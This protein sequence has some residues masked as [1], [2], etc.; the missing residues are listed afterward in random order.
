MFTIENNQLKVII[1]TKGAELQSIFHKS[2]QLEYM[3]NA[4]PA[5]WSKRSPVLF[6]IVGTVKDNKYLY[7]NKSYHL[8]RHG[9]ARE[10]EFAAYNQQVDFISFLLKSNETTLKNFP[11][12]FEFRVSYQLHENSLKTTYHILNTSDHD[13]YFS[14]GGHP[15][16]KLPLAEG[17]A[18]SDYYLEFDKNENLLRWPISAGGLIEKNPIPFLE[19]TK[20]LPLNKELFLQDALVFKHPASSS[21]SL[22]SKKTTHGLNFDFPG[23]PY[24][25]IWAA[26][27]ADFV[28]IEPWCGIADSVDADQQLIHKEGIIQLETGKEFERSWEVR[29]F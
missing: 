4:D 19:N 7:D 10:M 22:R 13:I 9:F 24:L 21:V 6:P 16:F 27:N 1:D 29:L 3:W 14:V 25:G 23:F 15:A 26:K 2:F 11:F 12:A 8:E 18:Y 5:F 28:C 17:T 20:I